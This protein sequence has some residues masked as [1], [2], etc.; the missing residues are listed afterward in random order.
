MSGE[1]GGDGA[2]LRQESTRSYDRRG[3]TK[4]S[5]R[6]LDGIQELPNETLT[7]IVI[8][9]IVIMTCHCVCFNR[10]LPT[11]QTDRHTESSTAPH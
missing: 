4:F 2:N 6:R 1:W 7:H 9:V 10:R 11:G 3:P 8:L 5:Y